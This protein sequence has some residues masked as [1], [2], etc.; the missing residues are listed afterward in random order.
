MTLWHAM[1]RMLSAS[2][3]SAVLVLA[4]RR[5]VS[6]PFDSEPGVGSIVHYKR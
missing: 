4:S 5:V 2:D 1:I 3:T 6:L